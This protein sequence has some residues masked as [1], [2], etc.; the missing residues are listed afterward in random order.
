M[1]RDRIGWLA[2]S[3]P[4]LL[5]GIFEFLRHRWLEHALPGPWGNVIGALLVA[6]GVFG[7]IQYFTRAVRETEQ[8]LGRS[9]AEAAVLAERHRIGREMHDG[10]AQVLFHLRVQLQETE[11][12][13]ARG[14]LEGARAGLT[15]V[16]HHV[17]AAY[18]QVRAAISDLKQQAGAEDAAEALQRAAGRAAQDLGLSVSLDVA[19]LPPL[20]PTAQ[21]H[22]AA[23]VLEAMSNARRHGGATTVKITASRTGLTISDNGSGFDTRRPRTDGFGLMIMEERA[24]IMGAQLRIESHP[25]TGTQVGLIWRSPGGIEA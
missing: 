19:Q 12:L 21:Q 16:Q 14:D 10:V 17:G 11:R 23:I 1:R 7:F 20:N 15:T 18:D 8:A 3:L 5:V 6:A 13:V 2:I 4:A 22:L 25:G 24:H 9:R